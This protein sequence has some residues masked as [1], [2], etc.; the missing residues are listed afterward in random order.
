MSLDNSASQ[1]EFGIRYMSTPPQASRR[2]FPAVESS[3]MSARHPAQTDPPRASHRIAPDETVHAG[4]FPGK[5]KDVCEFDHVRSGEKKQRLKPSLNDTNT[6]ALLGLTQSLAGTG[7]N[8]LKAICGFTSI[9]AGKRLSLNAGRFTENWSKFVSARS[10]EFPVVLAPGMASERQLPPGFLKAFR[11]S[12]SK[13]NWTLFRVGFLKPGRTR[14]HV[15][16]PRIDPRS[17]HSSPA[18]PRPS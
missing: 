15:R 17:H 4:V 10:L 14:T 13:P 3:D 8:P 16:Q 7:I 11:R 1:N 6:Q 18:H 2:E 12:I 5:P 9:L